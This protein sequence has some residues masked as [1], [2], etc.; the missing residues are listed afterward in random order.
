MTYR[1]I[2]A[3]KA[4]RI[5][6]HFRTH[7]A[8]TTARK[9]GVSVSSVWRLFNK[10]NQPGPSQVTTLHHKKHKHGRQNRKEDTNTQTPEV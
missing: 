5:R 2:T 10:V 4:Q 1:R 9:F 8:K 3:P 7:S 6:K